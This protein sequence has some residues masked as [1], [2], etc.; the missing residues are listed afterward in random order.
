MKPYCV[1]TLSKYP[2]HLDR[3]ISSLL[4]AQPNL[5]LDDIY[6]VDDGL[7]EASRKRWKV[8]Y[9]LGEKPFFF[10]RNFNIGMR[11]TPK[12]KDVFY[13]G[14][15]GALITQGGID[16]LATISQTWDHIG[17]I[18]PAITGPV[19]NFYQSEGVLDRVMPGKSLENLDSFCPTVV[20]VAV[21][22]KR[23]VADAVGPIPE[24]L[25]GYG[26]ED[27]YFCAK[28]LSL[29]FDWAIDPA[30]IIRHGIGKYRSAST[31]Q[32][33]GLDPAKMMIE[34]RKIYNQLKK[35]I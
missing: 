21:Y 30:V 26:Y 23:S 27:D 33:E 14:D 7:P 19:K 11:F 29:G 28:M 34:N 12:N 3:C 1:L 32:R 8:H 17:I 2:D 13:I 9:I 25:N 4:I 31:Y 35:K 16:R 20:F 24:E 15:D 5:S 10:A 22:L 6:V 18:S